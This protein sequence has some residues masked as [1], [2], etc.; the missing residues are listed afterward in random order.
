[1]IQKQFDT[2]KPFFSCHNCS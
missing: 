1:M 2:L